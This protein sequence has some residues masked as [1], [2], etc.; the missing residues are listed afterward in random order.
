MSKTNAIIP[1]DLNRIIS[2]GSTGTQLI[3]LMTG[4]IV[5]TGQWDGGIQFTNRPLRM[6]IGELIG[7]LL[8]R[9]GISF[10]WPDP[11]AGGMKLGFQG[12]IYSFTSDLCSGGVFFKNPIHLE[13]ICIHG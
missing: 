10:A 9:I 3:L 5:K 4:I 1:T 11:M 2:V 6:G 13:K 12:Q 8:W 7:L